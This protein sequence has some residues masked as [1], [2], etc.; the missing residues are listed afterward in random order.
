MVYSLCK[1]NRAV[2]TFYFW[3]SGKISQS[4]ISSPAQNFKVKRMVFSGGSAKSLWSLY[5]SGKL[6]AYPSPKP[7]FCPKWEV[8]V[9]VGLGE[10][11]VGSFPETYYNPKCCDAVTL[12]RCEKQGSAHS[13]AN[14]RLCFKNATFSFLKYKYTQEGV[15]VIIGLTGQ[16]QSLIYGRKANVKVLNSCR[17]LVTVLIR[18]IKWGRRCAHFTPHRTPPSHHQCFVLPE[19]TAS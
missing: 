7:T 9:N 18:L 19:F 17:Q 5:V 1:K 13:S 16:N 15:R 8:I 14:Q 6:P 11:R 12:F 3:W 4:R 10:G 2:K